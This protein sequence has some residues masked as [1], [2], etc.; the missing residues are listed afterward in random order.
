MFL[1]LCQAT[2]KTLVQQEEQLKKLETISALRETNKMLKMDRDKL[3]QELQQA[4]AK[5][6]LHCMSQ[7]VFMFVLASSVFFFS[8]CN[9][10]LQEL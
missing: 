9:L 7:F 6:S 8:N 4:Q 1:P 10:S 2:A 3:E 5:V